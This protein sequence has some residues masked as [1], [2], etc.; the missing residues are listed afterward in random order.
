M[1]GAG[2]ADIN[3][4]IPRNVNTPETRTPPT[5]E[6]NFS[7]LFIMRSEVESILGY[8]FDSFSYFTIFRHKIGNGATN[9]LINPNDLE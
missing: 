6:N 7:F 9:N 2:E 3:T 1:G 5:A 4:V 8:L